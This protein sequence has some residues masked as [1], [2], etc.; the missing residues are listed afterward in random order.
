MFG[1]R[2]EIKG[3]NDNKKFVEISLANKYRASFISFTKFQE[4]RYGNTYDF[5]IFEIN[6]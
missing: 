4:R 5:Y 2:H 3:I 6:I 1:I